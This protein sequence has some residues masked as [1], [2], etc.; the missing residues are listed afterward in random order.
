MTK[1][2]KLRVFWG[3]LVDQILTP[4]FVMI[5]SEF[6]DSLT[7]L[8]DHLL[9]RTRNLFQRDLGLDTKKVM[10]YPRQKSYF[11]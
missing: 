4:L 10:L 5:H 7:E 1:G 3:T 11:R 2:I 8:P 9:S 6:V